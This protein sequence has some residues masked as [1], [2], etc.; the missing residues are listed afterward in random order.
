MSTYQKISLILQAAFVCAMLYAGYTLNGLMDKIS[1]ISSNGARIVESVEHIAT[2]D[3]AQFLKSGESLAAASTLVG[4][5]AAGATAAMG[6]GAAAAITSIKKAMAAKAEATPAADD[7]N[8]G[9]KAMLK[10]KLAADG[11]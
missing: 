3:P 5:S 4:D 10:K 7:E 6:D 1:V 11:E 9:L 2:I 8:G